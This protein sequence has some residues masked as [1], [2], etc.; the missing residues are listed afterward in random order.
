M[1]TI[2]CQVLFEI[3]FT[4]YL[5]NWSIL[6]VYVNLYLLLYIIEI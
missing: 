2:S 5:L 6:F 1:N 4:L 3:D